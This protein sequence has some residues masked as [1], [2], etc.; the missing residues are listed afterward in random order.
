MVE[1]IG[2][3]EEAGRQQDELPRSLGLGERLEAVLDDALEALDVGEVEGERAAA[4]G[5]E[6][7]EA[8]LV[9]EAQQLLGLAQLRP[10]EGAGEELLGEAA[11]VLALAPRLADRTL[12]VSHG[13][14]ARS[15][16]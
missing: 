10:R 5:I 15:G 2:G 14:G 4:G 1:V 16:G 12:E 11:D 3:A 7:R 8:V 9:A 6:S 13:V